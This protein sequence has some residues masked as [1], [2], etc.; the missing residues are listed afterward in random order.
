M[1]CGSHIKIWNIAN[2]MKKWNKEHQ[3]LT[4]QFFANRCFLFCFSCGLLCKISNNKWTAKHLAQASCTELTLPQMFGPYKR[5][6]FFLKWPSIITG[7][8]K[9]F[10]LPPCLARLTTLKSPKSCFCI[11]SDTWIGWGVMTWHVPSASLGQDWGGVS[12]GKLCKLNHSYGVFKW[13]CMV[14]TRRKML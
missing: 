5:K 11:I 6:N 8:P 1:L 4:F 13:Y 3:T 9:C 14:C 7:T 2:Y 12:L 10:D